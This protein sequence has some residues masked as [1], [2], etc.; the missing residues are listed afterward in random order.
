MGGP[1]RSDRDQVRCKRDASERQARGK[2]DDDGEIG[3][4]LEELDD[5]PRALVGC[6]A[7]ERI[8]AL[9]HGGPPGVLAPAELDESRLYLMSLDIIK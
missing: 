7:V 4:H 6:K 1:A 2:R 8:L 5:R 9:E 3:S